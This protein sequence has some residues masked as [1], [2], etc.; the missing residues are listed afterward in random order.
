M[1]IYDHLYA[2]Y[3]GSVTLYDGTVLSFTALELATAYGVQDEPYVTIA[4]ASEVPQGEA[5]FDYIHLKPRQD[6]HYQSW[7][8]YAMDDGEQVTMGQ[9][10]DGSK[11]YTDQTDWEKMEKESGLL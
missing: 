4:N 10:F 1:A 7:Q 8:A 6:N 11:Q 9:D 3:P 5:Y 2:V